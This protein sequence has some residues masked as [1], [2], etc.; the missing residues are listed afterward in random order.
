MEEKIAR[1]VLEF[2]EIRVE[3]ASEHERLVRSCARII[4]ERFAKPIYPNPGESLAFSNMTPKTA[5]LA[6]DKVY[7]NP[8]LTDP[9]P[10][11]V[12]FYCATLPEMAFTAAG[13]FLLAAK[14]AGLAGKKVDKYLREERTAQVKAKNEA[15]TLRLFCSEMQIGLGISP[16]IF[17]HE[18]ASMEREFPD[19][20]HAILKSSISN[21]A[22]VDEASLTWEQVI[23][24]RNDLE[25]RKK[26]RRFVRWADSELEARSS[27]EMENLVAT[28]LDDY[29]WSLKKHGVRAS[30]GTISCLLDPKFLAGVSAATAAT[31]LATNSI[32]AA[33][34]GASLVIGKAVVAFGTEMVDG[35]EERRRDNYEVAYLYD[36]Q[37]RLK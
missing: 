16:T 36:I 8:A 1:F 34:A 29:E 27:K 33:L 19:G 17:Y 35:L 25:A 9:V 14:D 37:K 6:F 2:L 18:R 15:R 26:Y 32:W 31:A 20:A 24:F 3:P 10:E 23:E 11:E 30:L 28:R 13:T 7:R 12:G 4:K 21:I 5:A 22:M